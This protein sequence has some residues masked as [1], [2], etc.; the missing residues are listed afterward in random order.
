MLPV[1]LASARGTY[2]W[3]VLTVLVH[4]DKLFGEVVVLTFPG[5]ELEV[6]DHAV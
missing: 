5:F 2:Q 6:C 4:A 1:V 3:F